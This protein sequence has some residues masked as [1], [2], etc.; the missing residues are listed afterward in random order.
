MAVGPGST[1][2][3]AVRRGSRPRASGLVVEGAASAAGCCWFVIAAAGSC[4]S[5]GGAITPCDIRRR[6]CVSIL[7]TPQK[8]DKCSHPILT[9]RAN[10]F[11]HRLPA[12]HQTGESA[13]SSATCQSASVC[14]TRSLPGSTANRYSFRLFSVHCRRCVKQLE[15]R[16]TCTSLTRLLRTLCHTI[17]LS[18]RKHVAA[19]PDWSSLSWA[20]VDDDMQEQR[21]LLVAGGWCQIATEVCH[22]CVAR[23][24]GSDFDPA[25]PEGRHTGSVKTATGIASPA[26]LPSLADEATDSTVHSLVKSSH[27]RCVACAAAPEAST[28]DWDAFVSAGRQPRQ[29]PGLFDHGEHRQWRWHLGRVFGLAPP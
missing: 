18:I 9:C 11:T 8:M 13:C 19:A 1:S 10:S 12:G 15:K 5:G 20:E 17:S 3:A 28:D 21:C 24:R 4:L 6:Q 14:C 26:V 25:D 22:V 2:A 7:W 23:H 16:Y 29:R 27:R